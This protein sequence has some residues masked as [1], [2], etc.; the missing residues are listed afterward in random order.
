MKS[1]LLGLNHELQWKDPSGDLRRIL[2]GL[3]SSSPI[4]LIAEEACALPTTVARRLAYKL[5][6]PWL[7]IDISI[8]DRRLAGIYEALIERT[9]GPI[10]EEPNVGTRTYYLPREDGI[11]ETEWVTRIL[12]HRVDVALC[13]CGFLHIEP[14]AKKLQKC[15]CVVERLNLTE[16]DWFK[17]L[18]G[19]YSIV[20]EKGK[21][22]L[23]VR[24]RQRTS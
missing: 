3:L 8:A 20:E 6:K 17:E 12:R 15:A 2:N 10:P 9:H 22:W 4:D 13:V 7:E 24:Y 19:T 1:V 11:R 5:D 21:R 18:Y 23:E 14:F 16:E